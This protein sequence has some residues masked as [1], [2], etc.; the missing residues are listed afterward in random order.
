[1]NA[2]E[3]CHSRGFLYK[4]IGMCNEA[5]RQVNLCLRAERLER[6]AQ[7]REHAKKERAKLKALFDD[8]DRN[9]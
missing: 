3:D 6:T 8:V 4:A 7:H 1:M 9:S 2:L 5:K